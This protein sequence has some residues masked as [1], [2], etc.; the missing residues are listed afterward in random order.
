MANWQTSMKSSRSDAFCWDSDLIKGARVHYFATHPWDWTQRN[1]ND[2][3]DIFRGLAQS[4]SLLDKCI[5]EN[6]FVCIYRHTH[7]YPLPFWEHH[8]M[9]CYL[10]SMVSMACSA[11]SGD[12]LPSLYS[13]CRFLSVAGSI[14]C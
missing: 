12:F 9:L 5:F 13:Q 10:G 2:L 8:L 4:A 1:M 11:V 3:S 14:S 6:T 7:V